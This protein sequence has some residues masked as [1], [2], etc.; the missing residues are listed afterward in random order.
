TPGQMPA[1]SGF[2][3]PRA[4]WLGTISLP[5]ETK[6]VVGLRVFRG[7][8]PPTRWPCL[9]GRAVPR[10]FTALT[11]LAVCVAA[12]WA[13][14]DNA[15]TPKAAATR[16]LF[17]EKVTVDYKNALFRE[18]KEDLEEQVKGLKIMPDTRSGVQLNTK[19]TFSAKNMLLEDVLKGICEKNS[20]GY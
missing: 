6:I 7:T 14:D 15:D 9:G 12:L 3:V 11:V 20:W 18:V 4:I 5:A 10:L 13:A 1:A 8:A 16:K 19:I 17:K 2:Q